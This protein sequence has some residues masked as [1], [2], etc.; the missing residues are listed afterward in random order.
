[1]TT[2]R[3][4]QHRTAFH[5]QLAAKVL[6]KSATGIVSNADSSS[7][8]SKRIANGLF[9][10][11]GLTDTAEKIAGQTAGSDFEAICTDFLRAALADLAHL[12]PGHLLV[13]K[14]GKIAESQQYA[15]LDDLQA[16]ALSNRAI[17]TALGADYIIKP[18][19]VVLRLPEPDITINALAQ[20]V[21]DK[22]GRYS[23]LR[24][25]NDDRPIL[26]ASISCKWTIRSDRAQ[27]ARSEGLNLV[28]N[29]KGA[30]PHVAVVTGEPLPS[31]IASLALGTGDIDCVYHFALH[32]LQDV[33]A[34]PGMAI[35]RDT[36]DMLVEGQRLRD[37]SDLPLDLVI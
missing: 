17:A 13:H 31:R 26:H 20:I 22:V 29:R 18:D 9:D 19:V 1:M 30:L 21:D 7:T 6:T 3:L 2:A 16:I 25:M 8:P 36:L 27:N 32:E 28:R 34:E 11:L 4:T 33:M 23:G 15:H 12:R 10:S 14:G 37:V 5:R 24:Q 35:Y